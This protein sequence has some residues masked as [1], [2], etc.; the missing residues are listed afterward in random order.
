DYL[1]YQYFKSYGV[2]IIRTRGFN[3]TGPRQGDVYAC[4]TF[5]KQIALIEKGKQD[6][7]IKVGNLD[8]FRDFTDVRDMVR[9]YLLVVEKGEPGEVYNIAS[10]K[11]WQIKKVLDMLLDMSKTDIKVEEDPERMRPSDV[12]ILQG[13]ASKFKKQ[14]GW[15]P[16]YKF[17]QTLEDLLNYWR[18][19]V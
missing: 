12:E 8:S 10:G 14:T 18:E 5:A 3:H 17:E 15:E 13:D 11:T 7:V 9:A 16:K 2:R 6:P 19:R 1:G 4:S